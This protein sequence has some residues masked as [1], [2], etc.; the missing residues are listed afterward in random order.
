M[1]AYPEH[2]TLFDDG[3]YRWSYD[4]DMWHNKFM[5]SLIIKVMAVIFAFPAA[6]FL[7]MLLARVLPLLTQGEL[8]RVPREWITGEAVPLIITLICFAA[9][10]GVTL[11]VYVICAA[12]MH[13]TYRLCFEMDESAVALVRSAKAMN[14]VNALGTVATIAAIAAGKP[15]EAMRTSSMLTGANAVGTTAF[16]SVL[17]VK[18]HPKYDVINLHEVFSMNQIY[19]NEGDY[20]FVRDF[21][22]GHVR[23]KARGK[24][25][26]TYFEI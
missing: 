23:E 13:G 1:N 12:V 16:T 18:L 20:P 9:A 24:N 3:I 21:I 26:P 2:V 25:K 14:T 5:L 19:V 4:M 17:R 11:L 22:L 6:F 7:F 8:R 15:G 10:I